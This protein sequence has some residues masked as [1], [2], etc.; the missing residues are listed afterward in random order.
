M[1]FPDHDWAFDRHVPENHPAI[2]VAGEEA[3]V[4]P[5]EVHGVDLSG[6]AAQDV[7]RLGWWERRVL[8]LSGVAGG[9][10]A[11]G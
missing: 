11:Q 10:A 6:M 8:D 7:G 1:R 2:R 5:E 4:L 3:Q 9:H